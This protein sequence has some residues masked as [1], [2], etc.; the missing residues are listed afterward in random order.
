MMRWPSERTLEAGVAGQCRVGWM[1]SV[2]PGAARKLTRPVCAVSAE[3]VSSAP[4]QNQLTRLPLNPSQP[5]PVQCPLSVSDCHSQC[6]RRAVTLS[7]SVS[8]LHSSR[9]PLA[10]TASSS[11]S[12]S[13]SHP[14]S[15]QRPITA[16]QPRLSSTHSSHRSGRRCAVRR[17]HAQ[18]AQP[19][20]AQCDSLVTACVGYCAILHSLG[21]LS[22]S[23]IATSHAAVA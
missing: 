11:H 10:L 9:L 7:R 3:P 21:R 13:L 8:S 2:H 4:T 6:R 23:R 19:A 1:L 22:S 17:A 5:R 15:A 12:Q 18:P 20:S 16:L 14:T